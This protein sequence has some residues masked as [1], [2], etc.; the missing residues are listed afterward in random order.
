MVF[1]WLDP[2]HLNDES[3]IKTAGEALD[4]RKNR[5]GG[6]LFW[7]DRAKVP[8]HNWPM[9]T[10]QSSA[11]AVRYWRNDNNGQKWITWPDGREIKWK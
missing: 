10:E 3:A 2:A 5:V 4:D 11:E 1:A 8:V 9:T 7:T 6:V